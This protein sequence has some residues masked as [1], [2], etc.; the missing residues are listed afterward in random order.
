DVASRVVDSALSGSLSLRIPPL[1][2]QSPLTIPL[3]SPKRKR[4][5]PAKAKGERER[6]VETPQAKLQREW[7]SLSGK[8]RMDILRDRAMGGSKSPRSVS[9]Y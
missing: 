4:E 6:E 9:V 1:P 7:G 5:S 2:T 3:P 8:R